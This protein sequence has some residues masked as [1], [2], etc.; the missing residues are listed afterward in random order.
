MKEQFDVFGLD[1]PCIDLNLNV[2]GLPEL[3][4]GEMVN[5]L[6]WQ[7]GGK[8][9]SGLAACARLGAKCAIGGMVGDDVYGSFCY[10]DFIRHGINTDNL[11]IRKGATTHFSVVISDRKSQTRTMLFKMGNAERLT[12]QEID[13]EKIRSS[14]YLFIADASELT[15]K[16]V[17]FAKANGTKIF[18][19]ADMYSE[20]LE[21]MIPKIDVFVGSEF[22]FDGIFPGHKEKGVEQLEEECR[23]ICRRGPQIAVFTFGEKGCVGYSEDGFFVLPAFQVDAV[24]TVGAGDVFHGAFLAQLL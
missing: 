19:D 3:N 22:V 12:E 6:S 8:V 23:E 20:E 13:W 9:S 24:D 1:T 7:G 4:H 5:D 11:V 21:K 18:I 16:T 15:E 17:D 2:Q 10:G 14:K